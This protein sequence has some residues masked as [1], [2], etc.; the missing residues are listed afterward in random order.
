MA[1]MGSPAAFV[2][3]R[4]FAAWT[5]L[6]PRQAGTGGRICHLGISKRGNRYLR[7]LLMHAAGPPPCAPKRCTGRG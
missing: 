2:N 5:G 7:T 4:E 1:T 3:C 6:V